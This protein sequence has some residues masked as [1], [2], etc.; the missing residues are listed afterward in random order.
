M[1]E[2][3]ALIRLK[4]DAEGHNYAGIGGV[5]RCGAIW[6][7]P[8]CSVKIMLY[9]AFQL[10]KIITWNAE[11][12]GTTALL[13]VAVSHKKYHTLRKVRKAI[14]SGWSGIT[15][16]YAWK[17]WRKELGLDHYVRGVECTITENNGWHLHI[18]ALLFFDGPVSKEIV[19]S[20]TDSIY[21]EWSKGIKKAGLTA[22]RKRGIDIQIGR[23]AIERLGKYLSKMALE[24][25]ASRIKKRKDNE[26]AGRSPWEVLDD[27]VAT[28]LADDWDIWKEWVKGSKGMHQLHFSKGLKKLVLEDEE[29]LTEEQIAQMDEGGKTIAHLSASAW[30]FVYQVQEQVL[31]LTED[32]GPEGLYDWLDQHKLG[33]DIPRIS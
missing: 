3:G 4:K 33:Y 23:K 24:T 11:R 1:E 22:S 30:K 21:E 32:Q 26:Y 25:A 28:G 10:D 17:K 6:A 16:S 20:F 8:T 14:T 19:E 15:D 29:D 2:G 12:R 18:H 7:C 31:F 27:F 13:T 5:L 9:R